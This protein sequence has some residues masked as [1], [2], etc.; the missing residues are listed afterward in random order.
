MTNTQDLVAAFLAKGGKITKVAEG[1]RAIDEKTMRDVAHGSD[2]KREAALASVRGD[3]L[4]YARW[5]A[6]VQA[7]HVGDRQLAQDFA[8]G[9]LDD[10]LR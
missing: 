10:S 1:E 9:R 6:A 8:D 4:G 3:D 5:E 2:S 7:A